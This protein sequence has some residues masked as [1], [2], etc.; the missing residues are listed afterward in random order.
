[1]SSDFLP[2]F[3]S[4]ENPLGVFFVQRSTFVAGLTSV[5]KSENSLIICDLEGT[6]RSFDDVET[7]TVL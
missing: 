4:E 1:M 3:L 2:F 5:G 7:V 6:D